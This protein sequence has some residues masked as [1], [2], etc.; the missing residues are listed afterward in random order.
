VTAPD[1]SHL[2]DA[3]LVAFIGGYY[4]ATDPIPAGA[5]PASLDEAEELLLQWPPFLPRPSD[6]C[7]SSRALG[8]IADAAYLLGGDQ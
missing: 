6:A 4:D 3:E 7:E 1:L 5:I 2:T 8:E